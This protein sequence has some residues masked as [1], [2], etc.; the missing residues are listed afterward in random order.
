MSGSFKFGQLQSASHGRTAGHNPYL[1]PLAGDS[2]LSYHS[3]LS[4]QGG[5]TAKKELAGKGAEHKRAED[6]AKRLNAAL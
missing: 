5:E 6:E 1:D 2:S 3:R 4:P